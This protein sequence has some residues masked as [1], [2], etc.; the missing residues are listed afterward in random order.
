MT[1]PSVRNIEYILPYKTKKYSIII[2]TAGINHRI[3]INDCRSLLK[4]GQHTLIERQLL[5]L[6]KIFNRKE[7]IVVGGYYADRLYQNLPS[8]IIRAYN[9]D[10]N[11]TSVISSINVGL[12]CAS[13]DLII[14]IYGDLFFNKRL[15]SLPFRKESCVISNDLMN[16]RNVGINMD[17][18][19][20]V[21]MF[22]D[23][24]NKWAQV[25]FFMG[26]ELELL[27]QI[28]DDEKNSRMLGYEC[29]NQIIDMGGSF[30]VEKP[31]NGIAI[32]VDTVYD[33]STVRKHY[34][35]SL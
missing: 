7:I 21:S 32:D 23:L 27:R 20:L 5:I 29:I 13:S 12:K 8:S 26:K 15:L 16:D 35:N 34:A 18:G 24:P 1:N 3:K 17:G 19:R 25:A 2:P 4:V 31:R 28:C 11:D 6:D 14:I 33:L 22:Y 10:Y 30:G 9:S